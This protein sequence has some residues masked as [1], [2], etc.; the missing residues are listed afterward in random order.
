MNTFIIYIPLI[1]VLASVIISG[2]C[3]LITRNDVFLPF[4]IVYSILSIVIAV[5]THV[6]YTQNNTKHGIYMKCVDKYQFYGED[7][8]DVDKATIHANCESLIKSI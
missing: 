4:F 5:L 1:L 3:L 8:S 2:V 7:N 6:V